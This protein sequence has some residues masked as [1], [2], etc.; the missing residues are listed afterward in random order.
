MAGPPLEIE[1]DAAR[2]DTGPGEALIAAM[3]G[4]MAAMYSGL[5][6]DSES[7]P[8]AGPRELSAPGGTFIIGR[9]EGQVVC[10]GGVE[11]LDDRACE[12]KRM[13]VVPERRVQGMARR[14]R[15]GVRRRC[16]ETAAGGSSGR[17]F[18]G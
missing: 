9:L 7:M 3:R 14:L 18:T 2:V 1:F 6:L 15:S 11:R 17:R 12:I 10:C 16:S 4:E 13:Y 5:E 8:K